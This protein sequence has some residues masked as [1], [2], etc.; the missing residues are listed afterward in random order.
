[1]QNS[2]IN[3]SDR[4]SSRI[5]RFFDKSILQLAE[6]EKFLLEKSKE[7]LK[8]IKHSTIKN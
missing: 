5:F 8:A 6:F 7:M 2:L 1:M 4:V 3:Y